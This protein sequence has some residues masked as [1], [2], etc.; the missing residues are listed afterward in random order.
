MMSSYDDQD[1]ETHDR[2]QEQLLRERMLDG[3]HEDDIINEIMKDYAPEIAMEL[4][5]NPDLSEN[6]FRMVLSQLAVSYDEAPMVS[7]DDVEDFDAIITP[8]IWPKMQQ[9]DLITRGLRESFVRLDWPSSDSAVQEVRYRVIAPGH[10]VKC[11]A[12]EGQPDRPGCLTERRMRTRLDEAGQPIRVETFETWDITKEE[13]VFMIEELDERGDR[14]DRTGLYL[15]SD[16]YPYRDDEG[17]PIFPYV[18]Y[19]AQ[20]QD[21][22]WDYKAGIELVRGTLRLAV[23]YTAWWDA[24]NN[25]ANPQR[26][27]IDLELPAGQTQTLAQSRNVETITAGP[28]TILKFSSQRDG[29]GRIDTYPPGLSP[30]DGMTSLRAYAER[31]AVFAGL[32]PGDLVA[33]GSPQSGISIVVSRDG[34]RRAQAKAEPVNRLGDQQLLSIA[35]RLANAYGGTS[36]PTDERAYTIEYAQMGLSETERKTLIENLDREAGLG[37]VSRVTMVRELHPGLDS[38]EAALAF[39]VAQKQHENMLADALGEMEVEEQQGDA[40]VDGA[41]MEISAA[42]EM[43]RSGSVDRAAL[44]EALLA[45]V[46]ELGG[47]DDQPDLEDGEE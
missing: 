31:L 41:L 29:A 20:M 37:L 15:D 24:F 47:D 9:R 11:I 3:Q 34:Q 38:D 23:G 4:T 22:L 33:S 40:D 25:S 30:M 46:A 7:A 39:L 14:V 8:E 27:A 28:K 6:T 45:I 36:L 21:R 16:E 44:D 5:L 32:N 17:A 13:P 26:V 35:A 12:L 2:R 18:M 42:R 1:R 10:I 19:H 43:I